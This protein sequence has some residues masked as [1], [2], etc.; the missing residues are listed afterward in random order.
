MARFRP[1]DRLRFF[2]DFM[3]LPPVESVPFAKCIPFETKF[4][5]RLLGAVFPV[6]FRMTDAP[7]N[8]AMTIFRK[9]RWW[10]HASS[11]T[12]FPPT[13]RTCAQTIPQT[14]F[15][16]PNC[17]CRGAFRRTRPPLNRVTHEG[18]VPSDFPSAR[19]SPT[20]PSSW[21]K[22]PSHG[23]AATSSSRH[24]NY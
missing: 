1:P 16:M 4:I 9:I 8:P 6:K 22:M 10:G 2:A 19:S 13:V 21:L 14:K 15:P 24:D 20:S 23:P 18:T 3:A 7:D 17:H 11:V 12:T 5:S